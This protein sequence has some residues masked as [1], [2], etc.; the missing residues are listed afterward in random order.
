MS[1]YYFKVSVREG[2]RGFADDD[3]YTGGPYE[4]FAM[5]Y[6]ALFYFEPERIWHYLRHV[7]RMEIWLEGHQKVNVGTCGGYE[8][9]IDDLVHLNITKDIFDEIIT[10]LDNEQGEYVTSL[11]QVADTFKFE[12]INFSNWGG[13]MVNSRLCI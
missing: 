1:R 4:T 6:K 13:W 12:S 8:I 3:E 10:I 7:S 9:E 5:A 11:S 2:A